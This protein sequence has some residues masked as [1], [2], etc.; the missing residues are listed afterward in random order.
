MKD[1][2]WDVPE[3]QLYRMP[4]KFHNKAKGNGRVI[5]EDLSRLCLKR[6]GTI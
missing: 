5:G 4:Y 1:T 3:D 6:R 2:Y